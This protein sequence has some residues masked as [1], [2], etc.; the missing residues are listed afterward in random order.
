MKKQGE[1]YFVNDGPEGKKIGILVGRKVIV[2]EDVEGEWRKGDR[3]VV[4]FGH[5][6]AV[7]LVEVVEEA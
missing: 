4:T 3:V 5:V 7:E 2:F 6:D 1:I